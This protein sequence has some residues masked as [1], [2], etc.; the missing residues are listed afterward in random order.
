MF[1][2]LTSDGSGSVKRSSAI[3]VIFCIT[4]WAS[5]APF[6]NER[7]RAARHEARFSAL[8]RR[9]EYARNYLLYYK[10]ILYTSQIGDKKIIE[11]KIN[12]E[13]TKPKTTKYFFVFK[14]LQKKK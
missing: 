9:E 3:L 7:K 8:Y 4:C 14:Y 13:K 6:S 1:L 2:I 12:G 10:S 5:T 11:I